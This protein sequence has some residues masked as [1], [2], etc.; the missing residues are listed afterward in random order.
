MAPYPTYNVDPEHADNPKY[1]GLDPAYNDFADTFGRKN[2]EVRMMRDQWMKQYGPVDAFGPTTANYNPPGEIAADVQ[3]QHDIAVQ[4][5]NAGLSQAAQG[6]LRQGLDLFQSYRPGGA[7]SLAS[8]QY[9]QLANATLAGRMDPIDLMHEARRD[10]AREARNRQNRAGLISLGATVLGA[11]AGSFGGPAGA[12]AG[13]GAGR[14]LADAVNQRVN[15]DQGYSAAETSALLDREESVGDGTY[16]SQLGT[17]TGAETGVGMES[18]GGGQTMS[19]SL[20]GGGGTLPSRLDT[21]GQASPQGGGSASRPSSAPGQQQMTRPGTPFGVVTP[22]GAGRM[23]LSNAYVADS[24]EQRYGEPVDVMW[25][26]YSAETMVGFSDHML[27]RL[28]LLM[29]SDVGGGGYG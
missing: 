11:A 19:S 16:P 13:A 25:A 2:A 14:A 27:A 8:G 1:P 22:S 4:R 17:D 23:G 20:G 15:Q 29:A 24:Y 6:Y 28:D 26:N 9:G 10:Q 5:Y 3:L 18:G 21:G 7:A 12:L